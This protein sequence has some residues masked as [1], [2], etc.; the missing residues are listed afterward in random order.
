MITLVAVVLLFVVGAMAVLAIDI[1][2]FYTARS[3]AQR[4]ADSAALSAARALANS[5][6]TSNP[7]DTDLIADAKTVAANLA[8]QVATNNE[9]GGRDLLGTVNCANEVCVT[10]NDGDATFG[11]NP[12]VTVTVTRSDLPTFFARIWGKNL[13]TVTASAV[14]EAYN[15]SG[16]NLAVGGATPVAPICVKPWVLPNIDPT[17]PPLAPTPI[18]NPITGAIQNPSLLGVPTSGMF[19][20]ISNCTGN[21]CNSWLPPQPWRYYPGDP[22]SFPPPQQALPDCGG[23]PLNNYEKTIAG[24][25]TTPIACNSTLALDSSP[26]PGRNRETALAANCLTHSENDQGDQ[27]AIAPPNRSFQF[28]GGVDDPMAGTAGKNILVSDSV[29]TVPVYDSTAVAP[30]VNTPVQVIGFVQLFLN[31]DGIS[32]PVQ[33]GTTVKTVIV[34]LVGCGTSATGTPIYG[35]GPSAVAVRLIHP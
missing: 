32:T 26:H 6:L 24:C 12:H 7:A 22:S 20:A 4:T 11:T 34:N 2:T 29:V 13:V 31:P 28:L 15:P 23:A 35:N 21:S 3:E 10:F 9:V 14:A 19:K 8:L 18:F 16:V 33:A 25:V 17:S 1:A 5:G 30:I 27:V